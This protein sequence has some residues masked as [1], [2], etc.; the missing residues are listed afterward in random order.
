MTYA[1]IIGWGKCLPPGILTN[2]DLSTLLETNDEW[3]TTLTGI[4][5]RRISHVPVTELAYVAA[6]LNHDPSLC[7]NPNIKTGPVFGGQVT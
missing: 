6:L 5:Q 3:I 2:E 4:K 1:S 7:Q